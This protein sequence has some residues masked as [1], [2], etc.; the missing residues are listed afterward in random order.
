LSTAA[1]MRTE[2]A[3]RRAAVPLDPLRSGLEA[4]ALFFLVQTALLLRSQHLA[5]QFFASSVS[6]RWAS[7]MVGPIWPDLV[8]GVLPFTAI[9][10]SGV[11][12][13]R[14][15]RRCAWA[16][17]A[18]AWFAMS[19]FV[20]GPGHVPHPQPLGMGW[21]PPAGTPINSPAWWAQ[22]W[23]G[24]LVDYGLAL[25][26]AAVIAATVAAASPSRDD[27]ATTVVDRVRALRV[28][29]HAVAALTLCCFFVWLAITSSTEATNPT[30]PWSAAPGLLPP[31]LFGLVLGTRRRRL[32]WAAIAVPVL[33][34]VDAY[35]FIWPSA[36]ATASATLSVLP[37][38]AMCAVG[39][40]YRP[41]A[42]AFERLRDAPLAALVLLNV[43]NVA[44]AVLTWI[45]VRSHQAVEANPVVRM[46]GLPA[47]ILLVALIGLILYR[48]RPRAIV[49]G[50]AVL[51]A[52]IAW[53][54][55]GL[56]LTATV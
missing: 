30:Q 24:A 5:W 1:L 13:A 43:L 55:A 25:L 8:A 36:Q 44:D 34:Q 7:G 32:L 48:V 31:F 46:L 18:A 27:G 26:P 21:T 41:M 11:V 49:W 47:K 12:L 15:G 50:V 38:V 10:L 52:V 14:S 17:P 16:L 54:V 51:V 9:A 28:R 42:R 19:F 22:P 4:L 53:H 37:F 23:A 6:P 20:G 45:A 56:Y 35:S 39:V 2:R 40:A 29:P 3:T 33:F